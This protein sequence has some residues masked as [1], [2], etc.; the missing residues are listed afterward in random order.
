[1]ATKCRVGMTTDPDRR[2]AEWEAEIPNTTN[3]K[4]YGPYDSRED[5]QTAETTLAEKHGCESHPGGPE[6]KGNPQ[7]W[8]Y[9]FTY[10]EPAFASLLG[11]FYE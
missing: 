6:P 11:G 5:A 10:I 9:K 2:K 4:W 7:W 3:W 1:M 8:V